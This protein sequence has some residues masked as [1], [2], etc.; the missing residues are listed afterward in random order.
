[1]AAF[2]QVH[3]LLSSSG[4]YVCWRCHQGHHE[5]RA[6]AQNKGNSLAKF[7]K[8]VPHHLTLL[9]PDH[10]HSPCPHS[11]TLTPPP[12]PHTFTPSH[13]YSHSVTSSVSFSL[14]RPGTRERGRQSVSS[15]L[16]LR[17]LVTHATLPLPP[18]AIADMTRKDSRGKRVGHMVQRVDHMVQR[19]GHMI[20][21]VGHM[22]QR[23][24]TW[25]R[26]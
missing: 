16:W 13:R 22:I 8:G 3:C 15:L 26:G 25:Y 1:M 7:W 10:F 6:I 14:W 18:T 21:R 9:A 5:Q 17:S 11:Y 19:A 20:K 2:K 12:N 23:V 24:I 4:S